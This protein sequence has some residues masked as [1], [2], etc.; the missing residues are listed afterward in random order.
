MSLQGYDIS[1]NQALIP[2][3]QHLLNAFRSSGFPIYHTR[4]GRR[5]FRHSL[6]FPID[7]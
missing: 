2:K 6:S 5:K 3:L 1:A 7:Y 4:E